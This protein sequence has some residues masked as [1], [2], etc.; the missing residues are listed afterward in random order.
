MAGGSFT[1]GKW[2]TLL[3]VLCLALLGQDREAEYHLVPYT[4]ISARSPLRIVCKRTEKRGPVETARD[5][6]IQT[7]V[8]TLT[9]DE[10]VWNRETGEI[11][12][13]GNVRV[14]LNK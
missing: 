3:V 6:L 2:P 11:Q 9:A 5:P 10:M 12:M 13:R 8:L 7:R 1:M 4:S 14:K